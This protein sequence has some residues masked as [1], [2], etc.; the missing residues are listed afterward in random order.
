MN[1]SPILFLMTGLLFGTTLLAIGMALGYWVAKRN[2]GSDPFSGPSVDPKEFLSMVRSIAAWTNDIAGDVSQYQTQ[3]HQLAQLAREHTGTDSRE[4]RTILDQ[5]L[6]ANTHLQSRLESAEQKLDEQTTQ[7]EGYL[8]E[9]R[10]DALTGLANRR[11]FDQCMDELHAKHLRTHQAVTLALV[12][13]D[14]FKKIN[15]TY[16]HAAGDVVLQRVAE[17]LKSI[18]DQCHLVAR[19]G[20][21]EFGLIFTVPAKQAAAVME[22]LRATVADS[23]FQAEGHTIPVTLSSGVAQLLVGDRLGE[24]FRNSDAALY[25]AKEGGRNR[26]VLFE[27][28]P[29]NVPGR[30]GM[31]KTETPAQA[32]AASKAH[33]ANQRAAQNAANQIDEVEKRV[34]AHLDQL[35]SEESE[36]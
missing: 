21:E 16:G 3:M 5:I 20:G 4:L 18:A 23:V 30:P 2:R 1:Q 36:R 15:D 32:I 26:V 6:V 34:L 31:M 25:S 12:D 24:L 14:H 35:V 7:L 17:H 11:A 10:T 27:A 19:Y 13:I 9:A 33:S 22:R 8:T 28:S 29:S